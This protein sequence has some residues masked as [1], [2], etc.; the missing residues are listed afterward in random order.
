[1]RAL[2]KHPLVDC[3]LEEAALWY[4]HHDPALALRLI[5][6]TQRTIRLIAQDPERYSVRFASVRRAR[7][8]GFPHSLYFTIERDE[9]QILA[10]IHGAQE[11]ERILGAR[12]KTR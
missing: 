4:H 5:D 7:L 1:V 10:L 3:D 12:K 6:E 11:I 8:K 2:L 9:I